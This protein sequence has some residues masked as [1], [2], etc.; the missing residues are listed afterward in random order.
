MSLKN[1]GL[2]THVLS[3]TSRVLTSWM[4][5]LGSKDGLL[6]FLHILTLKTAISG[7]PTVINTAVENG[8]LIGHVLLKLVIVLIVMWKLLNIH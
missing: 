6:S 2:N 1:D 4:L 5:N 7:Y 8:T 3:R